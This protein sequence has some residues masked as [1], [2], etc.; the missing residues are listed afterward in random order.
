MMKEDWSTILL[1]YVCPGL[2]T[3]LCQFMFSAPYKDL[4]SALIVRDG[5]DGSSGSGLGDLNPT[6][7]AFMLGNCFGWVAYSFLLHDL[8]MF[9]ANAPGLILSIWLNTSAIKL[10]Y[11]QQRHQQQQQQQQGQ[12]LQEHRQ[13]EPK[14]PKTM[15]TSCWDDGDD[16]TK[17]RRRYVPSETP[18]ITSYSSSDEGQRDNNEEEDLHKVVMTTMSS[19]RTVSSHPPHY[20]KHEE[21]LIGIILVWVGAVS[22]VAFTES[23]SSTT[24][25]LILGSLVNVNSIFFNAAPLSTIRTV[26]KEQNSVTI[27]TRSMIL[28][29]MNGSFWCAYGIALMDPFIILPNVLGVSFGFIQIFL[30]CIFPRSRRNKVEEVVVVDFTVMDSS[31]NN[32][33][34]DEIDNVEVGLPKEE[35]LVVVEANEDKLM[36]G[37]TSGLTGCLVDDNDS[38]CSNHSS[39]CSRKEDAGS[40]DDECSVV[41][42]QDDY[43]SIYSA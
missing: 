22:L 17:R 27:H 5:D 36:L 10:L 3:I 42:D 9:W 25:E 6:P 16:V 30:C 2:G 29:T 26:V 19:S 18:S 8:W 12:Q 43:A 1:E 34:H 37:F 38:L 15:T 21:L 11:H 28:N 32:I 24:K 4:K 35:R 33:H 40:D 41:V 23:L 31:D 13:K 39:K 14:H 20:A 7:W